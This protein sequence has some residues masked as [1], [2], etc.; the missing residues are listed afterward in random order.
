[1]AISPDQ[2]RSALRHW[3]SGVA[4]VS[5]HGDGQHHGMTVSSFSSVSL[6][7]PL[8]SVCCAE[9]T[10]TLELIKASGQFA[11]SILSSSQRAVSDHFAAVDTMDD[12]F[13]GQ[14]YAVAENG[15]AVL[16]DAVAHLQCAV[17][18]QH[19]AGDHWIVVGELKAAHVLGGEALLFLD[20]QYGRF[21]VI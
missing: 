1:M 5:A 9:G 15:C 6:D 11:V 20:G 14:P 8:V 13:S 2:F 17:V 7:P 19:L 21:D 18:A 3:G 4:V 16:D 12:R 10:R